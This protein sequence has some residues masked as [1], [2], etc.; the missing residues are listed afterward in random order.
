MKMHFSFVSEALRRSG[1]WLR[2]SSFVFFSE[3]ETTIA[4]DSYSEAFT[5]SFVPNLYRCGFNLKWSIRGV[6]SREI[7][8]H[9]M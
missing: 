9:L 7:Y 1:D 8:F 6:F 3:D 5:S 2:G 4:C